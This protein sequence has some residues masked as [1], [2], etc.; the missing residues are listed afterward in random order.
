MI[1]KLYLLGMSKNNI[2]RTMNQNGFRIPRK[3]IRDYL[4]VD[5]YGNTSAFTR[6]R[7]RYKNVRKEFTHG[8]IS[9]LQK[10]RDHLNTNYL[11]YVTITLVKDKKIKHRGAIAK[12]VHPVMIGKYVI[13]WTY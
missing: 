12:F 1:S 3:E 5:M 9:D 8:M 7:S 10:G 2:Y 11:I 4:D 13:Q 6:Y